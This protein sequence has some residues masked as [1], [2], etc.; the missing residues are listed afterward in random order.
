MQCHVAANTPLMVLRPENPERMRP[1]VG[2][3]FV[4]LEEPIEGSQA[5]DFSPPTIP[6]RTFLR[7]NCVGCH[8]PKAP[9]EDLRMD[10]PERSSCQQCHVP[11]AGADFRAVIGGPR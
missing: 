4:G 2:N 10:H 8:N 5:H 7:E 9:N 6:H 3:E 11:G 1:K